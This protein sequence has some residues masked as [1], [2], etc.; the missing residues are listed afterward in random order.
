MRKVIASAL[1]LI[2]LFMA[3]S[4]AQ[5]FIYCTGYNQGLVDR[6]ILFGPPPPPTFDPSTWLDVCMAAPNDPYDIGQYGFTR[7]YVGN[8]FDKVV[9]T[10]K[11]LVK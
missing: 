7:F 5:E 9:D 1:L 10:I 4:A 2:V 3:G 11:D 8:W 6:T